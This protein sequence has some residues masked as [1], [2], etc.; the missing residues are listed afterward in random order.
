MKK[1]KQADVTTFKPV[2]RA[3]KDSSSSSSN[4]DSSNKESKKIP[5]KPKTIFSG[6]CIPLV[7]RGVS[8][9]SSSDTSES[10]S[11]S[12]RG[13]D[14]GS[15]LENYNQN[16]RSGNRC[17]DNSRKIDHKTNI[18]GHIGYLRFIMAGYTIKDNKL[19]HLHCN[20]NDHYMHER[21][22]QAADFFTQALEYIQY[23][24][25]T[26]AHKDLQ[27]SYL[28]KRSICY[29]RLE[30]YEN[31]LAD[32]EHLLS[33]R[34]SV[35]EWKRKAVALSKLNR[36]TEAV[37][38]IRACFL[39]Q[40]KNPHLSTKKRKRLNERLEKM[41]Q[42]DSEEER[43]RKRLEEEKENLPS[44]KKQKT[45]LKKPSDGKNLTE[46]P[47]KPSNKINQLTKQG[48]DELQKETDNY[49]YANPDVIC[50][51]FIK[52]EPAELVDLCSPPR[53][54]HSETNRT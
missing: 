12:G 39:L 6:P 13:R 44:S 27:I 36:P 34:N 2:S 30:Q 20:A 23:K 38:A 50:L 42:R 48:A 43:K 45:Q 32:C 19:R 37:A 5:S 15:G 18:I 16:R 21:Y 47:L 8:S 49:M 10:S 3:K 28:K 52:K 4:S 1:R 25:T 31:T 35:K 54:R 17:D 53:A 29:V 22:I 40:A 26:R 51:G 9:S 24:G 46:A 11:Q 7:K 14:N 33:I 41:Y